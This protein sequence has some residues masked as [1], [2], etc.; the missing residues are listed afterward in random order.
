MCLNP[1]AVFNP[2]NRSNRQLHG[3]AVK[4]AMLADE[5]DTVYRHHLM[6]RESNLQN[7]RRKIV[8][9]RLPVGRQ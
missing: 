3:D 5:W 9:F 8:C 1:F 4:R 2:C 6:G 7:L